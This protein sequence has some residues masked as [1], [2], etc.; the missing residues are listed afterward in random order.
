MEFSSFCFSKSILRVFWFRCVSLKIM[1]EI[2]FLLRSDFSRAVR[3][4]FY[5]FLT[6][7]LD[8]FSGILEGRLGGTMG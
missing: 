2:L 1:F 6:R 5:R 3:Y 4:V 8:F 7:E